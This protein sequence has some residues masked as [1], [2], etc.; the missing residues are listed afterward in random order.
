MVASG[1]QLQR[2]L[3]PPPWSSQLIFTRRAGNELRPQA[4]R[5]EAEDVVR[6]QVQSCTHDQESRRT[7]DVLMG[8]SL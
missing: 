6:R 4:R 3:L 2:R 7:H 5:R 8:S 1:P